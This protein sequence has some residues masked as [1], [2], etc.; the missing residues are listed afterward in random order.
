MPEVVK[1]YDPHA[2][3]HAA[4]RR[5]G[6]LIKSIA[7]GIM[8]II[9][10]AIASTW[11]LSLGYRWKNT[12]TAFSSGH[13]FVV[14]YGCAVSSSW[15]Y[16]RV[17]WYYEDLI[18][19]RVLAWQIANTSWGARTII[20]IWPLMLSC[21][22]GAAY[23]IVSLR[24]DFS[25]KHEVLVGAI[26]RSIIIL[27][28][29]AIGYGPLDRWLAVTKTF[30]QFNWAFYAASRVLGVIVVGSW[31]AKRL[32]IRLRAMEGS[33]KICGYDL[34]G[35]LSGICPECGTLTAPEN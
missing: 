25:R 24:K 22:A 4:T 28:I 21:L 32:K 31:T 14:E 18:W 7:I 13:V 8:A 23:L 33:C 11:V 3:C 17:D 35:N 6:R 29:L 27:I 16:H 15:D 30:H 9:V 10:I 26:T 12:F 34:K 20:P 1:S 19:D 5:G 2:I